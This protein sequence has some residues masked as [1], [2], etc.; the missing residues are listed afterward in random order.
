MKARYRERHREKLRE[1]NR[2]YAE[3]KRR[4]RGVPVMGSPESSE[5]RRQARKATGPEHGNWK[6]EAVGYVALHVWVQRHKPR[7]GACTN[8]GAL[9]RTEWANISGE[10]HR[11]LEDY[12]E[13]C[14][15]CHCRFDGAEL[16][17]GTATGYGHYGCRCDLCRAAST[18]RHRDYLRRKR[19]AVS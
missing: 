5:V 17:H 13:L 10:Y 19:E 4:A 8:C 12:V 14:K 18:E 7:T 16:K 15:R 3:Q 6:G 9:G 2:T 11:S 1:W